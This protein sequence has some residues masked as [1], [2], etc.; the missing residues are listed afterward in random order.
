MGLK[1]FSRAKRGFKTQN[2]PRL[3]ENTNFPGGERVPTQRFGG[4]T[5]PL[6]KAGIPPGS[7]FDFRRKKERKRKGALF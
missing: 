7:V 3:F 5:N 1:R 2:A 6:L 4:K